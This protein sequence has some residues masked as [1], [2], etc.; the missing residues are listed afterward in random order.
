M[1]EQLKEIIEYFTSR[2]TNLFLTKEDFYQLYNLA[3]NVPENGRIVEIGTGA[4]CSLVTMAVAS[5]AKTRGIEL[6]TIDLFQFAN[7]YEYGYSITK[8]N[9][10]AKFLENVKFW[11]LDAQ[12]LREH[13]IS[14]CKKIE[15]K[16]VDLLFI[17]GDH[18]Y[19]GVKADILNYSPK[20]KD[21]GILCGHD[22]QAVIP[23]VIKAVDE[24]FGKN[25]QVLG[26]SS[27]W[28]KK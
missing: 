24:I 18:Q 22:Y 10:L 7:Y 1:N 19:A 27:V 16:C 2:L 26:S 21:G 9:A 6:I 3:S 15:D 5:K 4:G 12:L 11:G 13:S 20:M 25:F 14:A 17:D 28:E 8:E 23:G